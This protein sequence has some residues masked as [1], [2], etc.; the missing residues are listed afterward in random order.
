MNTEITIHPRLHHLG[1][2]T[3]NLEAKIDWDRKA[4]GD[5]GRASD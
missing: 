1:L 2:T 5:D 3:S 4:P